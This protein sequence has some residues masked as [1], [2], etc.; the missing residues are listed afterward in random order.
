MCAAPLTWQ[1]RR[2]RWAGYADDSV[3]AF[4]HRSLASQPTLF[5]PRFLSLLAPGPP[6]WLLQ[7]AKFQEARKTMIKV[8]N[9]Q[10]NDDKHRKLEQI[11]DTTQVRWGS[12]G[13]AAAASR[14]ALA[15]N[16]VPTCRRVWRKRP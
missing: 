9:W 3:C 10:L 14:P 2:V 15:P 16:A 7:E 12:G 8:V 5:P 4:R 6:G 13:V 11:L 1:L